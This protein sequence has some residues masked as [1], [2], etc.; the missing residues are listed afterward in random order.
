MSW[1]DEC[2]LVTIRVVLQPSRIFSDCQISTETHRWSGLFPLSGIW[3]CTWG[4]IRVA[5]VVSGICV[6][7]NQVRESKQGTVQ[8]QWWW[9]RPYFWDFFGVMEIDST[10]PP[11]P[12]CCLYYFWTNKWRKLCL[13]AN[14]ARFVMPSGWE[15]WYT[16]SLLS[17]IGTPANRRCLLA[18]ISGRGQIELSS[19]C[20]TLPCDAT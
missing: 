9:K 7:E 20:I 10:A 15:G 2:S 1:S 4:R 19:K 3:E 5:S 8:K 18:H 13:E 17:I 12:H 14:G 16:L 6:H 11:S